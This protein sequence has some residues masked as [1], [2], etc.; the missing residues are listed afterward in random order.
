MNQKNR[1]TFKWFYFLPLTWVIGF[2]IEMILRLL[3]RIVVSLYFIVIEDKTMKELTEIIK[4]IN[5]SDNY[6]LIVGLIITPV[7]VFAY[8]VV[9]SQ[10][11]PD[12]RPKLKGRLLI[13]FGLLSSL[14]NMV[15]GFLNQESLN[16]YVGIE[17]IIL[18]IILKKFATSDE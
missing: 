4:S 16:L 13:F 15:Y 9:G 8:Y 2:V 5:L 10:L 11:G 12:S 7:L 6:K 18:L 17:S 14:I 1:E 3:I